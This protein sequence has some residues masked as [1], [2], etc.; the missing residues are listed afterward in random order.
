MSRNSLNSRRVLVTGAASGIGKAITSRFIR[1][2]WS[3]LALD[4]DLAKLRQ[5][6]VQ[7]K[8]RRLVA[9]P[10]DLSNLEGIDALVNSLA[11]QHGELD[12]LVNCAAVWYY[13]R[14]LE[15]TLEEWEQTFKINVAALFRLSQQVAKY[16]MPHGG[17]IVN[18]ASTNGLSGE[19]GWSLYDSSKAAVIG[20]TRTM[21]IELAR[22]NIL[23]N[24]VCPG[25]IGT[26]SNDA[27]LGD[28][29]VSAAWKLKIPMGRVGRAEEVA[30]TVWFLSSDDSTFVTGQTLVV[31]GGQTACAEPL[32]H[33][34]RTRSRK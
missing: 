13:R 25:M 23:V 26:Q 5:L 28:S 11:R 30:G 3:V 18:I 21:A 24:A 33:A 1:E 32:F 16:C 17:R 15:Q 31:D 4:R 7:M 14:F 27:L 2:G 6:S 19:A 12:A 22:R 10:Y 20:L 34:P 29:V 9:T 8:T